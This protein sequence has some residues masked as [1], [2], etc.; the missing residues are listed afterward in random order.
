ME[1]LNDKKQI[2]V[3]LLSYS[4]SAYSATFKNAKFLLS[5]LYWQLCNVILFHSTLVT[6]ITHVIC[7]T[8]LLPT[9]SFKLTQ[10]EVKMLLVTLLV[11]LI[12]KTHV[13][14]G[15]IRICLK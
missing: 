10:I 1:M 14:W 5:K 15:L 13:V 3:P 8:Q 11:F 7:N 12:H 9:F 2:T 6:F 4:V